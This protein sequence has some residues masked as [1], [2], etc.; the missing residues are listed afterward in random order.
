LY[1]FTKSNIIDGAIHYI[2]SKTR[3]GRPV[4]VQVPLNSIAK[5]ILAKYNNPESNEILPFGKKDYY[6]H[7]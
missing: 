2:A 5:E 4:T 6:G 7:F 1:R 3:D